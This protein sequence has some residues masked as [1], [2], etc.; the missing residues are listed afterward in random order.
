[1]RS[2]PTGF[3]ATSREILIA[4]KGSAERFLPP[5]CPR[6]FRAPG[7]EGS[8]L[9]YRSYR[10]DDPPSLVEI[11]NEAFL[12]RGAVQIRHGSALE[13]FVF[14]KP[15]FDPEGLIVA[16][17]DGVRVGFA[18]AGFGPNNAESAVSTAGGVTCLV[19]VRPS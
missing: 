14:A 8:A 19:G 10:N 5:G 17:Q 13:R 18:H 1:M 3:L 15:Y 7:L 2:L 4:R 12:S 9:E 16:V 11:W 6:S